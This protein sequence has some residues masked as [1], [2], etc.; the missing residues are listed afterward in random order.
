MPGLVS[1]CARHAE[2]EKRGDRVRD[3]GEVHGPMLRRPAPGFFG[4]RRG[5]DLE[6]AELGGEVEAVRRMRSMSGRHTM[7]LSPP[8]VWNSILA[9]LII[10]RRAALSVS[11]RA[12]LAFR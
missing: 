1:R 2:R 3:G 5:S 12:A 11:A 4:E 6:R 10:A 9:R 8:S 7:R